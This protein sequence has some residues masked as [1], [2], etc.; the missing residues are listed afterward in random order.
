MM[1]QHH[2][3]IKYYNYFKKY[4][5]FIYFPILLNFILKKH[6]IRVRDSWLLYARQKVFNLGQ[7]FENLT[8]RWRVCLL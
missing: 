5:L 2:L 6:S 7:D 4:F 1:F 3:D 8:E